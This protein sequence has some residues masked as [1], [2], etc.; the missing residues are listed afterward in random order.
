MHSIYTKIFAVTSTAL[1][2]SSSAWSADA[3]AQAATA[4]ANSSPPAT[5]HDHKSV[6]LTWQTL[7]QSGKPKAV[8]ALADKEQPSAL[9]QK[10][11][12]AGRVVSSKY[13]RA[14]DIK[15]FTGNTTYFAELPKRIR[16]RLTFVEF[17]AAGTVGETAE[18]SSM[19]NIDGAVI[20][21]QPSKVG[22]GK[23]VDLV[24]MDIKDGKQTWVPAGFSVSA[25]AADGLALTPRMAVRIDRSTNTWALYYTDIKL[26]DNLPL[27]SKGANAQ[28][29]VRAGVADGDKLLVKEIRIGNVATKRGADFLPATDGKID[30][31]KAKE[32]GDPRLHAD[33][34]IHPQR[35]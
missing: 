4:G 26:R 31:A 18:S 34:R 17:V 20:S 9:F 16:E 28:I 29:A 25:Q 32:Q 8:K 27:I 11:D 3:S 24:V 23:R 35:S 12:A 33:P 2:I 19:I 7:D 13:I 15:T 30:F 1:A 21:F 14:L 6:P 5:F 10:K 22:H